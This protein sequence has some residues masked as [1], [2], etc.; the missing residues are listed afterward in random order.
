MEVLKTRNAFPNSTQPVGTSGCKSAPDSVLRYTSFCLA[1]YTISRGTLLGPRTVLSTLANSGV[2][3]GRLPSSMADLSIKELYP[4]EFSSS[5]I[6]FRTRASSVHFLVPRSHYSTGLCPSDSNVS[7]HQGTLLTSLNGRLAFSSPLQQAWTD[8]TVIHRPS[9]SGALCKVL[10]PSLLD[11]SAK[12]GSNPIR[13]HL[14]FR[15]IFILE[16]KSSI[17][18]KNLCQV[19]ALGPRLLTALGHE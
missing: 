19:R 10:L 1:L 13:L 14:W 16:D 4:E 7:M 11:L 9:F 2:Y 12:V 8:G 3:F 18:R 15:S 6:S 5:S 17:E